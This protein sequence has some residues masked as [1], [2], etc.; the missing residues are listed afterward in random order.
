VIGRKAE[1]KNKKVERRRKIKEKGEGRRE[2]K[3]SKI[4]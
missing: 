1:G 3:N 4:R 2:N